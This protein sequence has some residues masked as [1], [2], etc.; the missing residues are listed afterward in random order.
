MGYSLLLLNLESDRLNPPFRDRIPEFRLTISIEFIVIVFSLFWFFDYPKAS[1]Y[2]EVVDNKNQKRQKQIQNT[3]KQT[4]NPCNPFP[5]TCSIGIWLH[6]VVGI[7]LPL[8]PA[9]LTSIQTARLRF[10]MGQTTEPEMEP[11]TDRPDC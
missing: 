10:R 6:V 1:Q 7:M 8:S 5:Y 3:Q 2:I 4:N 9:V 11:R